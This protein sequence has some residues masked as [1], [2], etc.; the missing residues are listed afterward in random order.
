MSKHFRKFGAPFLVLV[1]G[2]SFGLRYFTSLR[3]EFSRK[4]A[5]TEE[6]AEEFGLQ[7]RKEKV[8]LDSEYKRL[9]EME[10]DTWD[11]IRGPRPW[12]DSKTVQD[13]QRVNPS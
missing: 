2:G 8:T 9:Q 12:E 10:L 13:A 5:I 4:K 1:L 11:N 3:Y 7:M 6:E